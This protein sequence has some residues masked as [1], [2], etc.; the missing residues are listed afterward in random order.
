MDRKIWGIIIV[1]IALAIIAGTVYV[2]FFYKFSAPVE[3]VT[4][5][6]ANTT[7]QTPIVNQPT[8][9]VNEPIVTQPVEPLKKAEVSEADLARMASAFAERFGSFSNQSDYGNIRDL[10]IFMTPN[11]K[12]WAENYINDARSR[13]TDSAIYYGIITKA[14][15]SQ[16]KLYDADSGTAEFLVK[17]QR[18]E[19]AGVSGNSS[20][21][22]Q[23]IL[24]KYLREK[25]V[26]LLD[27]IYWQTK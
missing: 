19:S 11:L 25:G 27:G 9:S 6:T 16:S 15:S 26:W 7:T 20:T 13:K 24:I 23:D 4:E 18:R 21:F 14:V 10:E 2:I 1:I 17:T 5:S 3:P 12:V 22:Y 8:V